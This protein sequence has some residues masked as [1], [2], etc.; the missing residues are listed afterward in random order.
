MVRFAMKRRYDDKLH[1]EMPFGEA[2]ERKAKERPVVGR[3]LNRQGLPLW[4]R[5]FS[6]CRLGAPASHALIVPNQ[7]RTSN[8][9]SLPKPLDRRIRN[10]EYDA[11]R[12]EEQ[13]W[14]KWY[15]TVRWRAIRGRQ[16]AEQ[17]LCERCLDRGVTRAATVCHHKIAHRGDAVLFWR[18]PFGSSCADCHDT[19]EQRI[20]RGGQARQAVGAD[21]WPIA[22]M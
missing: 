11:R 3:A 9:V 7:T 17:P 4:R 21:G 13:P 16:L 20:E 22:T 1:L 8:R 5:C 12:R 10:R 2:L 14:R 15:A 19:D 6:R 18:G